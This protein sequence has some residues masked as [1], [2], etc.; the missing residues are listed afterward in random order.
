[1]GKKTLL[2]LSL[3]AL[4]IFTHPILAEAKEYELGSVFWT[5]GKFHYVNDN[6]DTKIYTDR[7]E[8]EFQYTSTYDGNHWLE[9]YNTIDN[10]GYPDVHMQYNNPANSNPC[11]N[12]DNFIL[13]HT[14]LLS[15]RSGNMFKM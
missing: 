7:P 4:I 5:A 11:N 10:G 3:A 9:F 15:C 12:I 1:M 6:W 13:T 14:Y 2:L 8:F